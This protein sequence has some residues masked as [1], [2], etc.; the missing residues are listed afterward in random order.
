[1]FIADRLRIGE[2]HRTKEG[3][4]AVRARSARAGIYD[5]LGREI[6]PD[7]KHFAADAT[8]K[9]YRPEEEVFN[10]DSV[11][12]FMLKPITDDHPAQPVTA[13]NW[14]NHAK[15][16]NAGALRDGEYL[17]FDLVL[18]DKAL[19]DAVER[20]KRELS[21]GYSSEIEI[22]Q[23]ITDAGEHYDAIQ[24]QIR[25]NHIAVVAKGRAGERCR[26]GDTACDSIQVDWLERLVR[27][28]RTYADDKSGDNKS[29]TDPR[30]EASDPS[31]GGAPTQDGVK[32]MANEV[33]MVDGLQ[34]EVTDAAKAAILK[35]QGQVKDADARADKAESDVAKLTTDNATLTADKAKLEQQLKDAE[36][37]PAK[38]QDAAKAY[39]GTV[40]K[41]K[42]I[43]PAVTVSDEMDEP[44]IRRAVVAARLGDAAK[45][46]SDEQVAISF[47]TL[48]SQTADAKADPIRGA[49]ASAPVHIADASAV[50]D[51]AR[52]SQY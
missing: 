11:Q 14:R 4:L 51:L 30:R 26:I 3:Y 5:Y 48:A 15:G 2:K 45:D 34:V 52:A 8:V 24:R 36:L 1:M 21:N 35:L 9:V 32:R 46:W 43:A 50:R 29:G 13:D 25:G 38:L 7:G 44:T 22:T 16:V 23:G 10:R 40:A 31:G 28:E 20:G 42:K 47:D 41:A 39:A 49:I 18:M 6:D 12:S 37:T 17:A 33:I 19:I 27:D